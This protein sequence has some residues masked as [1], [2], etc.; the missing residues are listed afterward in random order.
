MINSRSVGYPARIENWKLGNYVVKS[1]AVTVTEMPAAL[2]SEHSSG[3]GPMLGLL[4]AE[5]LARN[6][7]IIDIAGSTLYL[8][9]SDR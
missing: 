3:E 9:P 5:V 2:T 7:A 8:K 6:S 1:S 4:G